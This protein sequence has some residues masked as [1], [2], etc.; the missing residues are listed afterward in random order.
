MRGIGRVAVATATVLGVS[1]CMGLALAGEPAQKSIRNGVFT[2]EQVAAGKQ[3]FADV[4]SEC[5]TSDTF[6]PDYM[7]GWAGAT[8]G[9]L[10]AELQATM[11]YESPGTLE[12]VEYASVIVYLFS[13][14][15]VAAGESEL[16]TDVTAL[17]DIN[18]EGPFTWNGSNR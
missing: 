9:E 17:Y 6:G 15:G 18:I 11:P 5:H 7:E 2:A 12:D 10:F 13:M 4:C 14:N 1:L 3:V 16:P 8:V